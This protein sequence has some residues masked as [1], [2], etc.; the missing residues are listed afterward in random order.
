MLFISICSSSASQDDATTPTRFD[1]MSLILHLHSSVLCRT[2]ASVHF[3]PQRP[4]QSRICQV[5]SIPRPHDDKAGP[6]SWYSSQFSRCLAGQSVSGSP[7]SSTVMTDSLLSKRALFLLF[8]FWMIRKS[9]PLQRGV[10]DLFPSRR[11]ITCIL[12][13]LGLSPSL[14]ESLVHSTPY[15]YPCP[16]FSVVGPPIP[17]HLFNLI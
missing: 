15:P 13:S 9:M 7:R 12:D 16:L 6:C 3:P 2:S 11:I 4:R 17:F 1:S 8:R 5:Q 14:I 10:T